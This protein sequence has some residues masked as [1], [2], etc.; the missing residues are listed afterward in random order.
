MNYMKNIFFLLLVFFGYTSNAQSLLPSIGQFTQPLDTDPICYYPVTLDNSGFCDPGPEVGDTMPDFTLYDMANND[1]TLSDNIVPGKYTLLVSGSYTCPVFRNKVSVIN[2][3][4]N[5]YSNDVNTY[6][7]Y[8]M[9]AHPA[10]DTSLYFGYVNPGSANT[11]QGILFDQPT[12]YG[13]RK[14]IIDTMNANLNLLAPILIDGPCNEFLDYF[15]PAPNNAYLVDSNGVIV[16]KHCWF[17]NFPVSIVND[18]DSIVLGGS[19]GSNG[20]NGSFIFTLDNNDSLAVGNSGDMLTLGGTFTNTDPLDDVVIDITRLSNNMPDPSW[21]SAMC[22]NVCLGSNVDNYTLQ[23]PPNSTQH[24]SFYFF[25]GSI[26]SGD[27]Q[28]QFTNANNPSNTITQGLYGSTLS[29]GLNGVAN[30]TF[31]NLYPNP[32][33]DIVTVESEKME[34]EEIEI[35]TIR[36]E[37]VTLFAKISKIDTKKLILDMSSLQSGTYFIRVASETFRINKL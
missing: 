25:T 34:L 21:T 11:Q 15:G 10:A 2:T 31:I 28:L 26:A 35:F 36:G 3:V 9:E 32:A 30:E 1:F 16:L 20:I 5:N 13:E 6:V 14:A 17:D 18:L 4:V 24:F 27:A 7:V 37:N 22:I 29:S 8:Q 19:S 12:T 33:I 23:M